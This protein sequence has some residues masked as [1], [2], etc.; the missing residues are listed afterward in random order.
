MEREDDLLQ[1][2]EKIRK[3]LEPPPPEPPPENFIEEFKRF[4]MRYQVL[5][6]AVAFIMGIYLGQLVQS[7]VKNLIMP[8]VQLALPGVPWEDITLGP[9]GVGAF[10]GDLIT[11]IIIAFVVFIIVKLANRMGIE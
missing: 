2:V 1:E 3:L 10:V 7:L 11:F 4:L 5:G 8:I 6:L 9:F